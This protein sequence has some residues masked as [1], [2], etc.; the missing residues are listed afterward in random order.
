MR[1]KPNFCLGA[2][3]RVLNS[4]AV[5]FVLG[6]SNAVQAEPSLIVATDDNGLLKELPQQLLQSGLELSDLDTTSSTAV[7]EAL[8]DASGEVVVLHKIENPDTDVLAESLRVLGQLGDRAT[9]IVFIDQA[10]D[11]DW[12]SDLSIPDNV[13]LATSVRSQDQLAVTEVYDALD[14][15]YDGTGVRYDYAAAVELAFEQINVA[16]GRIDQ[17]ALQEWETGVSTMFFDP[18]IM[19]SGASSDAAGAFMSTVQE[20]YGGDEVPWDTAFGVTSPPAAGFVLTSEWGGVMAGTVLTECVGSER[21]DGMIG[22]GIKFQS[23]GTE[24][25]Q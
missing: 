8:A 25:Q 1:L 24:L 7:V 18:G 6:F 9:Y 19:S 11:F 13:K 2:E 20:T 16:S 3:L 4:L 12:V 14:V 22:Q 17:A 21:W 5:V 15:S 10:D 23:F